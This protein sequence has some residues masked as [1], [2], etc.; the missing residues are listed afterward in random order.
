VRLLFLAHRLPYPPN[1][2]DKVRSYHLLKHLAAQHEVHL[3]TFIDDPEDE[4]HLPAVRKLCASVHVSRIHPGRARLRSLCGL[5]RREPLSLTY[6]RDR[7]L[8][9][10]VD[11]S[12]QQRRFD[13]VLAFSSSMVPFALPL[14]IPMLVDFVDVDS[15]KWTQYGA[16]HPW[17]L[18]WLY[19]REGRLLLAFERR[20]AGLAQASFFVTEKEV[21]L[22]ESLA[23]E[24]AGL[25]SAIGNG[26]DADYFAPDPMVASPFGSGEIPIVFTGAMDY[27]PNVDAA[28]WF[29]EAMLP[30]LRARWPAIRFHVV[31]RSPTAAVQALRSAGVNVTGTVPDVRPYL[32]HAAAVVAPLRLARGVQNKILEAMAMARPVVAA[33]SC[34]ES[35]DATP[36]VELLASSEPDE[37]TAA[38]SGLIAEPHR[39]QAMGHAARTR[40]VGDYSWSARLRALDSRLSDAAV[41][42]VRSRS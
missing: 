6:Y 22:F 7:S 23:P 25:A 3:G 40:V 5:A 38:V 18:S 36:G 26:V 9:H 24:C 11:E 17:P 42:R 10:W 12:M 2:G 35:I 39:A 15:A 14:P 30:G 4:V 34:V 28:I 33:A 21:A 16:E 29:T 27:W 13:A 37:Y 32:Q 20:I 1:K 31:G 19:R 8:T 41:A